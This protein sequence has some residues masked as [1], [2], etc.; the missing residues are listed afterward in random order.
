ML[1]EAFRGIM[2]KNN[3]KVV[4]IKDYTPFYVFVSQNKVDRRILNRC[5]NHTTPYSIYSIYTV[6][7]TYIFN[8]NV[9]RRMINMF[10]LHL[11]WL[12]VSAGP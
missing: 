11:L 10:N 9:I 8:D 2:K 7:S 1:P 4:I 5:P 6:Y 3:N 12:F